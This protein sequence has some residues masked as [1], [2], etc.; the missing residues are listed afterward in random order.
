[1]WSVGAVLA[2]LLGRRPLFPGRDF[3]DQ[4]KIVVSV[5]GSP[6]EGEIAHVT[7]PTARAFLASLPVT[8]PTP[9]TDLLPDA[10]PDA[11]DLLS[12]LLCFDPAHRLSAAE[13]LDHPYVAAY[14]EPALE[15]EA[16]EDVLSAGPLE[17]PAGDLPPS[18]LRALMWREVLLFHPTAV[19]VTAQEGGGSGAKLDVQWTGESESPRSSMP[20]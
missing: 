8:P 7:S 15:V 5:L 16:G 11:L 3:R 19:G 4:I 6:G 12:R 9:L 13:A 1:M 18:V 2:D 10:P 17:P 20:V 14:H